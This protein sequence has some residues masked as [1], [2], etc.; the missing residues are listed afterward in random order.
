MLSDFW[1]F[2]QLSLYGALEACIQAPLT[3]REQRLVAMLEYLEIERYTEFRSCR[4]VGR[5]PYNRSFMARAFVAKAYYDLK[6]TKDLIRALL[7]EPGLRWICGF[8]DTVPVPSESTFSRAFQEFAKAGLGDFC[9]EGQTRTR[10][11]QT[12]VLHLS[13]DSTSLRGREKPAPKDPN[14]PKRKWDDRP[15]ERQYEQSATEALQNIPRTCGV[16]RKPNSQGNLETCV[17]YKVHVDW[18]D[19]MIPANVQTT[20]S[21]V[22]DSQLAIPMMRVT[23]HRVPNIVYQLMDSAYDAPAIRQACSDLNQ[24][25]LI[26]GIRSRKSYVPFEPFQERRFGERTNAERGFS[27]LKESFGLCNVRVRGHCKVHLHVM[28]S[29]LALFADQML[30]PL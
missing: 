9:H 11:G 16:G 10:V 29:I 28:F 14:P 22:H 12:P 25:A 26:E 5:T 23:A 17:G 24:V 7:A 8:G 3:D 19:G 6:T 20:S 18:L 13:R 1:S 15:T 4:A 27:R 21:A 30:R 2:L